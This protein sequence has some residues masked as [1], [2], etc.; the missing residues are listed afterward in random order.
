MTTTKKK[1]TKRFNFQ[2]NRDNTSHTAGANT[3]TITTKGY[4]TTNGKYS[5]TVSTAE[6]TTVRMTVQEARALRNF[7]NTTLTD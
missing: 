1:D 3:F 6:G 4:D 2:V 5:G 7:L